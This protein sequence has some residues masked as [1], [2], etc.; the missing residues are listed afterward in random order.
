LAKTILFS[1][2]AAICSAQKEWINYKRFSIKI[3]I[4][5]VSHAPAKLLARLH[6]LGTTW[7]ILEQLG[8]A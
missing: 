8:T 6:L 1:L 5:A 3:R 2:S 7:D 4:F